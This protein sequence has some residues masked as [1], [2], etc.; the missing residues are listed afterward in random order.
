[1]VRIVDPPQGDRQDAG[2]A[3]YTVDDDGDTAWE[4]QRFTRSDFGHL[5]KGMG[6]LIN[7]GTPR[8]LAEVHVET[9]ESGVGMD[10][11]SGPNDPGDTSSGDAKI[12]DTYKKL[13]DGDT[14]TT[15]GTREVF[16]PFEA[17]Q[18]YQYVLVFLTELPKAD[19]GRGGYKVSVDKIELYG[20]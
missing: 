19:D 8:A 3:K 20:Y 7:L 2:Q 12:V 11:R 6:V 14:K 5:K 17:N 4:T 13:G 15:D 18:K 16:S 1:M 9:S 10:I